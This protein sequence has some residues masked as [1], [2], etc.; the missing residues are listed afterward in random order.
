MYKIIDFK[1]LKQYY[2]IRSSNNCKIIDDI[3][4]EIFKDMLV[5]EISDLKIRTSDGFILYQ[6]LGIKIMR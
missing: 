6:Y 4:L 1:N 3:L 5:L 2:R